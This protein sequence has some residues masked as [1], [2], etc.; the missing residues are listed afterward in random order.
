MKKWYRLLN[1]QDF[2]TIVNEDGYQ[3]TYKGYRIGGAGI[4]PQKSVSEET[5]TAQIKNFQEMAAFS[6]EK[7]LSGS[8]EA[9][10]YKKIKEV[11]G[12]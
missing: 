7:I 4:E 3:I 11:A 10:Y 12:I 1:R 9:R 2:G 5:R 6:I 8:G